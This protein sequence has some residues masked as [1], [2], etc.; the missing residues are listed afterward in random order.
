MPDLTAAPSLDTDP[1]L[2][3]GKLPVTPREAVTEPTPPKKR[4]GGYRR[5]LSP[6]AMVLPFVAVA[7]VLW[8]AWMTKA[9]A[10]LKAQKTP[11]AAVHL[12]PLIEE[13]VQGQARSGTPE[14]LVMRQTQ[15]FMAALD[16]ELLKRGQNGTTVL[17][18]EAVLSKNVPDVTADVRRAVYAKVETPAPGSQAQP[19]VSA[20]PG[21]MAPAGMGAR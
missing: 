7:A 16:A 3:G 2:F 1:D 19:G 12:Q 10:D 11:I 8:G 20:M 21:A 5:G 9:V 15:A 18:A 6:V 4:R 13:Y 17:V 14:Q